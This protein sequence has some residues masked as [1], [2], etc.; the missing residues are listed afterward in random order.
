MYSSNK[1]VSESTSEKWSIH[2]RIFDAGIDTGCEQYSLII[3]HHFTLN[4]G[5]FANGKKYFLQTYFLNWT[6]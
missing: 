1:V 5:Y 3:F 6:F 2:T 4:T